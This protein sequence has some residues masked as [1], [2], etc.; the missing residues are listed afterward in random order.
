MTSSATGVCD[1]AL[2][3]Y[4]GTCQFKRAFDTLPP[5]VALT[6]ALAVV[7][8]FLACGLI[9]LVSKSRKK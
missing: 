2:N 4:S 1:A 6:L 5:D 3:R 9:A 7:V 8:L